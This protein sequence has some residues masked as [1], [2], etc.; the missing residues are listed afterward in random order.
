MAVPSVEQS[1]EEVAELEGR[2]PRLD[3]ELRE[4]ERVYKNLLA[5]DPQTPELRDQ[6]AQLRERKNAIPGQ[7]A[8]IQTR[9]A[10]A[11][12]ELEELQKSVANGNARKA[13]LASEEGSA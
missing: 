11:G 12:L 10:R 3:R 2:E 7:I 8:E 1:G 9:R 5:A 6:Q 4:A 13:A